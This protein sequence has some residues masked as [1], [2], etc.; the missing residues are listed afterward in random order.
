MPLHSFQ[1]CQSISLV[2]KL[3]MSLHYFYI[4]QGILPRVLSLDLIFCFSLGC[5]CL[6][7]F[8]FPVIAF[9]F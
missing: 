8:P 5:V 7:D 6:F 1:I 2:Y 4:A 3:D 9:L